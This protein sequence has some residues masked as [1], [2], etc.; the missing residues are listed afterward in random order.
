[1][2]ERGLPFR[3]HE[4]MFGSPGNGNYMGILELV[5]KY[6]SFLAT[7]IEKYGNPGYGMKSYLSSTICDELICVMGNRVLSV[8]VQELK[9]VKYYSICIDSTPDISH[10]DQLSI[11]VRYVKEDGPVERFLSFIDIKTHTGRGLAT[12]L[13]DF[14]RTNKIDISDCRGQSYGNASNMSGTYNGVQAHI[15]SVNPLATYIPCFAHALNLVGANAVDCC[16]LTV[17]FF[18]VVQRVYTFF[19]ASTHRW[20]ILVSALDKQAPVPKKLSDTRWS[21]HADATSALRKGFKRVLYALE[22]ITR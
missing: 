16:P 18:D 14:L 22:Q 7:H 15:L 3:G 1:M 6:D 2:A 8:I 12:V 19:A 21:C 4:E 11:V 13:L 5:A 17:R 10:V 20:S 9:M